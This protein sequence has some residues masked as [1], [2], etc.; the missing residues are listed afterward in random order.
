MNYTTL[1]KLKKTKN[2]ILTQDFDSCYICG[3]E[4]VQCHHIFNGADKE[5]SEELGLLIPVCVSCHKKVH[6]VDGGKTLKEEAQREYLVKIF[7]R[8]Y[9]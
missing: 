6:D 1:A 3:E 9:L 8:C 2:S 7:G 5:L 4:A